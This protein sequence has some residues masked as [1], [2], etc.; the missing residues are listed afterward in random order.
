MLHTAFA[1]VAPF[2]AMPTSCFFQAGFSE[3]DFA[4]KEE[5]HWKMAV[6]SL[7]DMYTDHILK[8]YV[9]HSI[10]LVQ[11]CMFLDRSPNLLD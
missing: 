4:R 3:E 7:E 9:N 8:T 10:S 2:S 1:Q 6:V 5:T 11:A